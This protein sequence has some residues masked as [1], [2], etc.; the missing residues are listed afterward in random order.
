M[1]GDKMCNTV[2]KLSTCI[3]ISVIFTVTDA[4]DDGEDGNDVVVASDEEEYTGTTS[5][6]CLRANNGDESKDIR[7]LLGLSFTAPTTAR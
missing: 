6:E 1:K 2:Y 7:D 3:F 5:G 4:E